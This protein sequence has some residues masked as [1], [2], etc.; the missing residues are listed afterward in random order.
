MLIDI[1]VMEYFNSLNK[2]TYTFVSICMFKYVYLKV[3]I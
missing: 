2:L 3:S 1:L